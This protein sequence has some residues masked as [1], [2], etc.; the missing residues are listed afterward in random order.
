M[1]VDVQICSLQMCNF[2]IDFLKLFIKTMDFV[3]TQYGASLTKN[4]V[5]TQCIAS[6]SDLIMY[7]L[8]LA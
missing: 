5:E 7:E 3:E 4:V 1:P 6:R 8:S 2:W